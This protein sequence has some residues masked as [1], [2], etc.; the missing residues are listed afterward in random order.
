MAERIIE[1]TV[2]EALVAG[3]HNQI[4]PD[5]DN[6]ST[7]SVGN[8]VIHDGEI[9]KCNTAITTVTGW[10]PTKWTKVAISDLLWFGT[11]AEYTAQAANI[12]VGTL[13]II[14]DDGATT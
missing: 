1:K 2:L 12:P 14:T 9:Y 8:I 10:D 6:Y 5:F 13:I 4:A 7:Y 11:T 3:L